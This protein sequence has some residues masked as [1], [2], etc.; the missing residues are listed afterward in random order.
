M[1]AHILFSALAFTIVLALIPAACRLAREAGFVDRPGGRKQ[2]AGAVP[3]VGGLVVVP[4]F[5][6]LGL[7]DALEMQD[8]PRLPFF[9][10]FAALGMLMLVGGWDDRFTSPPWLRFAVQGLAA[11][12]IVIPGQ[13]HIEALGN[14]FGFGTVWLGPMA[15]PFAIVATVLLINA[16]NLMDGLDGLAGGISLIALA[17]LLIL[18]AGAPEMFG[19]LL[20]SAA[21]LAG[22]LAYN[23]RTPWRKQASVFLGDSG[24]LALGATL[25]WACLHSARAPDIAAPPIAV[26]WILAL[27]IFDVC[28]QFARR[29]S[30][31]RHPF[32]ADAHH[33]H[34][35]F[36]NAGMAPGRATAT[37]LGLVFATGLVGVGGTVWLR[38]PEAALSWSWIGLL[39]LHIYLSLRPQRMRRLIR[40]A[41]RIRA[42]RSP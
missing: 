39:L 29:L 28:G 24:S 18:S 32:D 5:I 1:M 17:W 42:E 41:F 3:P 7:I 13:A 16:V 35:H 31:G 37:I 6:A 10:L 14:L 36:V 27:P 12:L 15:I 21:A 9:S 4:V 25:A 8:M 30:Q 11:L 38:M 23:L 40:A 26:A 33:F 2:H 34:H 19:F 22:F 20:I